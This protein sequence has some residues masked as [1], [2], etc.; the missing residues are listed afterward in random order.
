M[1]TETARIETDKMDKLRMLSDLTGHSVKWM[2]DMAIELFLTQEAPVYEEA[3]REAR[4][5]LR[6]KRHPVASAAR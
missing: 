2:I 3:Y 1:K 4:K 5:K 6:A